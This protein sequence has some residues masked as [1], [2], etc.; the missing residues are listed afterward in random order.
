[1]QRESEAGLQAA[2]NAGELQA[3]VQPLVELASAL[4]TGLVLVLAA[5]LAIERVITVGQLTLAIAYTR[6]TLGALR[7]LAKLSTQTQKAAV[8][9]ERLHEILDTARVLNDP[10]RPRRLPGG[11]PPLPLEPV[12]FGYTPHNPTPLDL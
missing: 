12:T 5:T 7:Q 11:A 2:L 1:M 6:G 4:L 3:R 10:A 9:A 8:G